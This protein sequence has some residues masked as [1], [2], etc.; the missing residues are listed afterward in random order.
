MSVIGKDAQVVEDH[1][2]AEGN[3]PVNMMDIQ[4]IFAYLPH[5]YPFLFIDRVTDLVLGESIT[6]LKNVTV[7]EPY[8][9]GHFP[10]VPIMPGVLIIEAMAQATGILAFTTSQKKP[11]DDAIYLLVG[12]DQVRFRRQV[13]PGDQLIINVSFQTRKRDL[14]KF[15]GH[16][17]VDGDTVAQAVILCTE[18]VRDE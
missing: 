9:I 5:R 15:T 4:K 8:F 16:C 11:H 13:V 17:S 7:N 3:D 14:W 1:G 12:V 6:A 18:K 2:S 10:S